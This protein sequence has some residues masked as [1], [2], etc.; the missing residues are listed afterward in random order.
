M[1]DPNKRFMERYRTEPDFRKRVIASTKKYQATE[2]GH[3]NLM[4][5]QKERIKE[6]YYREYFRKR[7]IKAKAKGLCM[8]CCSRKR[9]KGFAC[10]TKCVKDYRDYYEAK[11][12]SKHRD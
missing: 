12:Q 7:R 10:C 8:R 4:K 9:K 11:R 1:F 3:R 6:G 2:V 5:I